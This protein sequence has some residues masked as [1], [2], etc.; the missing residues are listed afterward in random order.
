ME[1]PQSGSKLHGKECA[2]ACKH[3][4]VYHQAKWFDKLNNDYKYACC[5]VD[6][7]CM[8]YVAPKEEISTEETYINEGDISS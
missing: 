6:C 4:S 3:S 2:G 8:E 5:S 7:P 1:R